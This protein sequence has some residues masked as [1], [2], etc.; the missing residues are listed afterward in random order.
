MAAELLISRIGDDAALKGDVGDDVRAV[1]DAV[2][3]VPR[4]KLK[5]A[6]IQNRVLRLIQAQR[7]VP[8]AG[9]VAARADADVAHD[10]VGLAGEGD[11]PALETD[12]A[13][14]SRLAGD[15]EIAF[16]RDGGIERD[17][18]AHI[19]HDGAPART[20]RVTKGTGAAVCQSG[21]VIN[22]AVT[23]AGR[24]R[25]KPQRAGKR[26]R[27]RRRL[28]AGNDDDN[29]R[30]AQHQRGIKQTDNGIHHT[31]LIWNGNYIYQHFW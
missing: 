27:L 29:Q 21:D 12:A 24:N 19:E 23:S 1:A 6:M 18:A 4:R 5:G 11:F 7:I 10:D 3:V 2:N 17:V 14:G 28:E 16:G 22:R 9:R 13:A 31:N 25:T 30:R 26:N 20:H 8:G 15:G